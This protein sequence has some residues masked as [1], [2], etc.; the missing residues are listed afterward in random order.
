MKKYLLLVV[1]ATLATFA[2]AAIDDM[3]TYQGLNFRVTSEDKHTAEVD[4]NSNASGNVSIPSE[5]VNGSSTYTVNSIRS[6]AFANCRDLTSVTIPNSVTSIGGNAFSGCSS[7]TEISVEAGNPNYS[8]VD[9]VLF[10]KDKTLLIQCPCGKNGEYVIPNSVTS[11]WYAAFQSCRGLTSI[12]IPNSVTS[13][14][15]GVAFYD[16]ISLTEISVEAGNPSYSSANGALFNKDI[17]LLIKCPQGFKGEY[18][19]PNTVTSIDGTAF[20]YCSGLTSVTI[21]NSVTSIGDYAFSLCTGLKTLTIPCALTSIGAGVFSNCSGLTSV[22]IPKSVTSI[23]DS[24]FDFCENLKA[25]YDLN[26]TPQA[27]GEYPFGRVP[28]DA[29]VYVPAGSVDAYRMA[30]GWNYFSNF[31][32]LT[33]GIDNVAADATSSVDVFDLCGVSVLRNADTDALTT[34]PAGIYIVRRGPHTSKIIIR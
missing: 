28:R 2:R 29:V 27:I 30:E 8:S 18:V 15:G 12:T 34:L 3:F 13:F 24:A 19:I 20:Y 16:C 17:T 21:P 26:P 7:L 5:A 10:N 25:I 6:S 1:A 23:G 4:K 22:I 11:I 33:S 32:E 14:D 9:G 31:Q